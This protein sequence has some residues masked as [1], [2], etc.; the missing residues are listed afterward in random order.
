MGVYEE[1]ELQ[2]KMK[3]GGAF[4]VKAVADPNGAPIYSGNW[5]A[6]GFGISAT[7]LTDDGQEATVEMVTTAKGLA[8]RKVI[9]PD[10]EEQAFAEARLKRVNAAP[11]KDQ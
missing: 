9:D 7:V 8:I 1:D 2:V 10:G 3:P 6:T 5:K 4:V 11:K